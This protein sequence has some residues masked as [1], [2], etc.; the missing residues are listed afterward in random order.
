MERGSERN[1]K[2]TQERKNVRRK[3]KRCLCFYGMA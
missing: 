2:E 3:R 1:M